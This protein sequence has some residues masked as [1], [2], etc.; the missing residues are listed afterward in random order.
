[1]SIGSFALFIGRRK[2]QVLLCHILS[3]AIKM[4][5]KCGAPTQYDPYNKLQ[6]NCTPSQEL[7]QDAGGILI[8]QIFEKAMTRDKCICLGNK[9]NQNKN[10]LAIRKEP[11]FIFF[12]TLQFFR[13]FC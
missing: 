11:F 4:R 8:G 7:P 13:D 6:L 2:A 10:K 3:Q 9:K 5:T 1:M 12:T